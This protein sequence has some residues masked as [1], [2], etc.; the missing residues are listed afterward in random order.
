LVAD[1]NERSFPDLRQKIAGVVTA[2][3][4]VARE[5]VELAWECSTPMLFNHV[6]RSYYFG[7]LLAGPDDAKRDD[8]VVFLSTTL[9]D[10]GLTD[11]ARGPRRFEIEGADAAKRFLSHREFDRHRMWLVWDTIALHTWS[12]INL[13]KEP[14]A[15]IA[16]LGIVCDVVGTGLEKIKPSRVAEV[17]STF[18]RH[19][20]NRGFLDLLLDEAKDK[21][22]THI[23]HPVHMI[24]HHC[25][26]AVPIPDIRPML[27]ASPFAE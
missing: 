6:M 12:D 13:S 24:G 14:E 19:D 27:E 10:L 22:E 5:A 9:H 3:T 25:C 11:H 23:V 8:E 7:Q 26:A 4:R 18:P 2:D 1:V 16:Q 20:F 15:R 21:P 17:L